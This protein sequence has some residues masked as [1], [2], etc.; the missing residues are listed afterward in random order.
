MDEYNRFGLID[1]AAAKPLRKRV[2]KLRPP[3]GDTLLSRSYMPL[4]LEVGPWI[5]DLNLNPEIDNLWRKIGWHANWG[6][7]VFSKHDFKSVRLHFKK[8]NQIEMAEGFQQFFFRYYDPRVLREF[9][10]TLN[11]HDRS[12]FFERAVAISCPDVYPKRHI[13]FRA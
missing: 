10:P 13:V 2:M 3:R 11:Q 6:V 1:L 9:I 8:Y 4:L 12:K 7:V 5:V